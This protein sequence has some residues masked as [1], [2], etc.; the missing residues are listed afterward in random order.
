MEQRLTLCNFLALR[1]AM[2]LVT[3]LYDGHLA[4]TGLRATQYS[5][6]ATLERTGPVTVQELADRLVLD[7]T[8]LTRNLAP[9]Q[10]QSLV[11]IQQGRDRRRR[12]IHL[13]SAGE[14]KRLEAHPLWMEAQRRFE[15]VYGQSKAEKLRRRLRRVVELSTPLLSGVG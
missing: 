14:A 6:L 4:P 15:G 1:Q 8:T 10:R 9:L 7:R 5:I 3:Q 2:R 13:T 12:E 11:A